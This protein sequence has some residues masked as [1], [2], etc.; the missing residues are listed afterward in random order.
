MSDLSYGGALNGQMAHLASVHLPVERKF[1]LKLPFSSVLV[2][3][4][5]VVIMYLTGLGEC[6]PDS[7]ILYLE[8]EIERLLSRRSFCNWESRV[9]ESTRIK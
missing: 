6:K 1:S 9:E 2:I 7:C 5:S 4:A 3:L 8:G